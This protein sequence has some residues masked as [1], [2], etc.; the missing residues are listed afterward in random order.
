MSTFSPSRRARFLDIHVPLSFQLFT[1]LDL[2]NSLYVWFW[3]HIFAVFGFSFFFFF[4]LFLHAA[5]ASSTL[6][7]MSSL[8]FFLPVF[9]L[10][11]SLS[12]RARSFYGFPISRPFL[13]PPFRSPAALIRL[14]PV[15]VVSFFSPVKEVSPQRDLGDFA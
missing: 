7:V 15:R 5:M 1:F 9:D 13:V 14:Y 4:G 6:F 10:V 8:R 3:P 12:P 2:G 11:F